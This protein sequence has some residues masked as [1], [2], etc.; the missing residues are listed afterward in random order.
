MRS[1][2]LLYVL[3]L[4][5]SLFENSKD[6][7]FNSAFYSIIFSYND[8][9]LSYVVFFWVFFFTSYSIVCVCVCVCVGKRGWG[10]VGG[11]V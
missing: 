3:I 4:E 9:T 10:G 7:F 1:N 6:F 11:S 5:V 8:H 2:E